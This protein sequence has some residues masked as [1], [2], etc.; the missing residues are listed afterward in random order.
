MSFK[1]LPLI[2]I[3]LCGYVYLKSTDRYNIGLARASRMEFPIYLI[4]S[5]M[6]V[7][8]LIFLFLSFMALA[9]VKL[10]DSYPCL[11]WFNAVS[12]FIKE[13]LTFSF[14]TKVSENQWPFIRFIIQ[15][16]TFLMLA[17]ILSS[18]TNIWDVI[19]GNDQYKISKNALCKYG[20]EFDEMFLASMTE[21][22][23]INVT[24]KN[25]KVYIGIVAEIP[26]PKRDTSHVRLLPIYSGYRNEDNFAIK[27]VED[28]ES[29]YRDQ[30]FDISNF[31]VTVATSEI[32][33]ISFFKKS[34]YDYFSANKYDININD[35]DVTPTE[36]QYP[37]Y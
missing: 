28:Y 7:F 25:R 4:I 16:L 10:L 13:L 34:T 31:V 21:F 33:T 1:F 23:I 6:T 37:K 15:V 5:G 36:N 19:R 32:M 30:E 29:A 17:R 12:D 35:F 11:T 3:A 20:N 9:S 24:L 18:M 14:E 2:L 26:D 8:F 22:K 27:I